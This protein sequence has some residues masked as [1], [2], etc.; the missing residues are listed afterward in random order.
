MMLP[1]G[2]LRFLRIK[3]P[4]PTIPWE[5]RF[6][7]ASFKLLRVAPD[8]LT[9]QGR[10]IIARDII[11]PVW[12]KAKAEAFIKDRF[13]HAYC[14]DT[15][16]YLLRQA[17]ASTKGGMSSPGK[18]REN[19]AE[20]DG[21]GVVFERIKGVL[22]EMP[23]LGDLAIYQRKE[24]TWN[25]HVMPVLG[26]D[27]SEVLV[28]EGNHSKSRKASPD[29]IQ[30]C[31]A[32]ARSSTKIEGFGV[33]ILEVDAREKDSLDGFYLTCFVRPNPEIFS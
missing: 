29:S 30:D 32:A 7:N 11:Q 27:G 2:L 28:S 14:G 19:W 12:G 3:P 25:G 23:R 15:A 1:I 21:F 17:G 13:T 5:L 8:E 24:K 16:D 18:I 22:P 26:S 33:R 31:W 10:K 6:L 9:L 20:R 4:R